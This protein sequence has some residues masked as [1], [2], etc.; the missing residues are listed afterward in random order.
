M[1]VFDTAEDKKKKK[2]SAEHDTDPTAGR[3][4]NKE[5]D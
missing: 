4:L 1:V 2:K 3:Q 5:R